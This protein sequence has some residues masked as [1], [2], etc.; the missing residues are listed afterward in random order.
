MKRQAKSSRTRAAQPAAR[1]KR[2]QFPTT[3][4]ITGLA[5]MGVALI[6]IWLIPV[7]EVA[8]IEAPAKPAQASGIPTWTVGMLRPDGL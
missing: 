6:A 8:R 7:Q 1:S 2:R 5:L 3:A 4:V